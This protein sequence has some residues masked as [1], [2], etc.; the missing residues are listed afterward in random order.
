MMLSQGFSLLCH[1]LLC[2]MCLGTGW[3]AQSGDTCSDLLPQYTW[4]E[5]LSLSLFPSYSL[6]QGLSRDS[7]IC[8]RLLVEF[9]NNSAAL[10]SCLV[11]NARPVRLCQHCYTEYVQLQTTMQSIETPMQNGTVS[12]DTSLLQSDRVQVV[13]ILNDFFEQT[14]EESKCL[15]CLQNQS[16][17][18]LNTTCEFMDMFLSLQTCFK[19]NMKEPIVVTQ[20][21]N[22]SSVCR[23]CSKNY[24][25][26]NDLYSKLEKEK[27]LCID[28]E[29]A[30]NSTRI[31]WSKTFNCTVPCTDTVPV[32]AVSAFIL[33]LP[34]IFYLSSYLHSEQKKRK[35]IFPSRIKSHANAVNIQHKCN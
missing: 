17:S 33:F 16:Q 31:L 6:A 26:L 22:Y 18:L 2:G 10:S 8:L 9:A 35:L 4:A 3:L 20:Q 30:M 27:A 7:D 28:L 34:V 32:I 29:D 12:C 23:N 13:V 21:G 19:L 5:E 15:Q 1:L 25:E 14:W 11:T 24:R